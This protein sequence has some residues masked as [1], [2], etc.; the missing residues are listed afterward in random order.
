MRAHRPAILLVFLL[1][2]TSPASAQWSGSGEAVLVV[3]D[4]FSVFRAETGEEVVHLLVKDEILVAQG[5]GRRF[6]EAGARVKVE[7]VVR[8]GKRSRTARGWIAL[9][10][11]LL[12][13]S[14]P[15]RCAQGCWPFEE[16]GRDLRWNR[17]VQEAAAAATLAATAPEP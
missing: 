17:C 3:S 12:R 8:D 15:C 9:G 2:A 5:S 4:T 14:F 7:Y 16:E 11:E 13:F 6:P 1:L 10:P